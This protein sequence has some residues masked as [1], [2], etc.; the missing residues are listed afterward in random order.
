[1]FVGDVSH[2]RQECLGAL[3][4][5]SYLMHLGEQIK[6][7]GHVKVSGMKARGTAVFFAS[8]KLERYQ[9]RLSLFLI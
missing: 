1:M 5:I 2:Y 4:N 3:S 8:L 9:E 7:Q 6:T